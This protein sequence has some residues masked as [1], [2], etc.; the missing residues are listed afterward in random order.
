MAFFG[1]K[2]LGKGHELKN[3]F[4]ERFHMQGFHMH[5]RIF[6]YQGYFRTV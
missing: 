5:K 3:N 1:S 6:Q 4:K 2:N